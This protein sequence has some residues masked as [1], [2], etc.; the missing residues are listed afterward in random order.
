MIINFIGNFKSGYVGEQ[1]DQVHLARELEALGHT[2]RRIP[3]DEWREYVIEGFPQDKYPN[4]PK[5]LKADINLITKWHHFFDGSF[6]NKLRE[7]SGAPVF[8]WVWDFMWDQG[9]PE[10]HVEMVQAADLYLGNDVRAPYYGGL[11]NAYYFPFDVADGEVTSYVAQAQVQDVAFFGSWIGQG[12]R[13][14]WLKEINKEYPVTVY[15][16]N[17]QDWPKEFT[18]VRPA[19]YGE[20]FIQEVRKCKVVLGFS[21]EPNSWGYWSNRVGKTLLAGGFLLYQYAPGMELF[22]RDGV[23]YFNSIEEAKEKIKYFLDNSQERYKIATRGH[24]LAIDNFTSR[25]RIKELNILME[26]YLKTNGKGWQI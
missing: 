2:V 13:Q 17:Y 19:V 15:S 26:R 24:D 18:D 6:I 7:V 8:Y 12:N 1:A 4:V 25:A 23:E 21:V 14:E 3:Q 5:D 16:W 20:A 9:L 22:L 10:W 11:S